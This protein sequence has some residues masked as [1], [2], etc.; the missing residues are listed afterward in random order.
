MCTRVL[1]KVGPTVSSHIAH[2][3]E[4]PLLH[5][6]SKMLTLMCRPPSCSCQLVLLSLPTC[7]RC[8]RGATGVFTTENK[9]PSSSNL[10]CTAH[11]HNP[12][13]PH[14]TAVVGDRCQDGDCGEGLV[15]VSCLPASSKMNTDSDGFIH[16]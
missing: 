11:P 4:L 7:F 12:P 2:M 10:P 14:T 15:N 9:S 8:Y 5:L 3:E 1:R 6:S 13:A 16:H